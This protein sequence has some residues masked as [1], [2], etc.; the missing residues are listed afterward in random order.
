MGYNDIITDMTAC[1][2][3][4]GVYYEM[5]EEEKTLFQEVYFRNDVMISNWLGLAG[6]T[7]KQ[8]AGTIELELEDTLRFTGNCYETTD[9]TILN[10]SRIDNDASNSISVDVNNGED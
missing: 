2:F 8:L 9:K 7:F 3:Y 1:G 4:G 10:A 5:T 6:D